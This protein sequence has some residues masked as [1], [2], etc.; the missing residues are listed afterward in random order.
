MAEGT[1]I[2]A[3]A[4]RITADIGDFITMVGRVDTELAKLGK[5]VDAHT[6]EWLKFGAAAASAGAAVFA[7]TKYTTD[8]V[9]QLGKMAQK[10]GMN[11]EALSG[12]SYAAKLSDVSLDQLG[13]GLKQLS[14]WMVENQVTGLSVEEQLLKIAD[15]FAKAEDDENKTAAAMKY[16]GKSGADL[17]PLL[18]GGRAGIEELRKEAAKLGIVFSTEAAKKAEEFND[19]LTRLKAAATGM[20]VEFAG[21]MVEALNKTAQAMLNAKLN[22]EDLFK[23]LVEGFRRL[24]TGDDAHKWNVEFTDATDRMLAAQNNV[25]RLSRL[26][27]WAASRGLQKAKE[28]LEAAKADVQRLLA[29]KPVLAPEEKP[30]EEPKKKGSVDAPFDRAAFEKREEEVRG[31]IRKAGEEREKL[32][33]EQ[34]ARRNEEN[35]KAEAAAL[36][37]QIQLLEENQAQ[38]DEMAIAAADRQKL[39]KEFQFKT[40]EELE[41]EAHAARMARLAIFSEE[42]LA[43]IGGKQKVE[44]ELEQ[45]HMNRLFQI[46]SQGLNTL[47]QFQKASFQQQAKT[48][49]GE[50]ANITAGVA[51]SNR[52]LFEINKVAGISN[53]IINAYEG[54][55]R[56]MAKYPYPLNMAMA[57]L[58][59]AAAFAQVNAIRSASF[60]GGGSAPSI[61]GG[62]P[63]A[64]VSPVSSGDG[65][66]GRG[67]QTTVVHL[68]GETFG[69]KQV[70]ELLEQ[71]ADEQRDGGRVEFA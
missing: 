65:G 41:N 53:A 51:Q 9:D 43:A 37:S 26:G 19:N 28:D 60:G 4:V 70:R 34:I 6:R 11:V 66:I 64:P 7:F 63:A 61:A 25:D 59:G 5:K 44:A 69:R 3:L 30:K 58:H 71:I 62:T 48:I 36:A 20:A 14:K 29:I 12:L 8:T 68:H 33:L 57:A 16:F 39:L 38:R 42:E 18:N 47:A 46:R 40:D 24:V 54:I 13:T 45:E 67:G 52:K 15:A 35:A 32:E 1:G 23:T 49:F 10:V 56:T 21:P 22:G 27:G 17:I 50:I 31:A 55:S 2:G